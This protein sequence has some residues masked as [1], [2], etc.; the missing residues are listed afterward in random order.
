M[1]RKV[2]LERLSS[3]EQLD[4]LITLTSPI[5]WAAL[6]AVAVLLA[7]IVAWGF[8]GSIPT[9]VEGAGILVSRGGQVFDAMAPAGGTL[10]EVAAIGTGVRKGDVIARLDD[11]QAEQDL[12]H[13]RN[14]LHEQQNDLAQLIDH[15]NHQIEARKQVDAEQHENLANA[16]ASAEQRRNFYGDALKKEEPIAAKGF[17]TS[18]FMQDTRQQMETAEQDGTRARSELLRIDAEELDL[19]ERRE[20]EV[21]HQQEAVNAA[22]RQLDELTVRARRETRVISPIDGH[23]TE[24]KAS[25]GTVVATG[26]PIVSIETAGQGLELVLYIPPEQGKNVAPGMEV[27]IEPST[28]KKEEF[29]TLLGHVL[30]ISEFPVSGQGMTATLQNPQLVSRFSAQGAPY[31]ARVG[32]IAD[33]GTPSGYAWAAGKGPPVKLSSGTTADAEVTVR[34]Q[35]PITLVLPLLRRRTGIGG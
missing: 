5:G 30:A 21:H 23:V 33:A 14:V 15:F 3:P 2:A 26:R 13:A 6:I 18:R 34:T 11:V 24:A 20:E 9:R 7:A 35:A 29:G 28:I 10:A 16:I 31:A 27:R 19:A 25:T 4:Q 8:S 17:L 12:Q 32:L 1:F 22:Q